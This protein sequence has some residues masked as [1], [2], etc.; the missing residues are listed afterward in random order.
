M[1]QVAQI[2]RQ[3]QSTLQV[4]NKIKIISKTVKQK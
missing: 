3:L 4:G 2:H 1:V